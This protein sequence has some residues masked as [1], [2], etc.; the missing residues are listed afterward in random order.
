MALAGCSADGGDAPGDGDAG[1]GGAD[2]TDGT[3][4]MDGPPAAPDED[5]GS[6]EPAG[7][8]GEEANETA[9]DPVTWTVTVKDDSFDPQSLTIQV[10]DQVTWVHE[11]QNAHTVT[12]DQSGDTSVDDGEQMDT[13]DSHPDCDPLLVPLPI[14]DC[15]ANGDTFPYTFQVVDTVSYRCKVHDG[16]TG[17]IT[18]L[19]NYSAT[20]DTE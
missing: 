20:P 16:M 6:E 14:D 15:M 9:R 10:G 12:A 11:G 13:F 8:D 19:G 1:D 3:D 4:G 17:T 7:D 2:G 18:V 5:G